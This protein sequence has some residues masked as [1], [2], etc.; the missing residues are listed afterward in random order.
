M[1][2]TAPS[3]TAHEP[4]VRLMN[5]SDHQI[6]VVVTG[7]LDEAGAA[8]LEASL[9]RKLPAATRRVELDL[10]GLTECGA[11]GVA[12]LARCLSLGRHFDAGISVS[13]ANEAGRRALLGSMASV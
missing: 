6:R 11:A 2:P 7:S 3:T 10:R 9:R 8:L 12:A 4:G 13:V 5:V 1:D